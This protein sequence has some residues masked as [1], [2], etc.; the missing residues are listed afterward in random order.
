MNREIAEQLMRS[1]LALGESLNAA[2]TSIDQ[3]PDEEERARLRKDIGQ[4]MQDVYLVLMRPIVGQYPDLD[5]D[6]K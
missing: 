5:P 2:T 6:R 4:L 3:I 1:F